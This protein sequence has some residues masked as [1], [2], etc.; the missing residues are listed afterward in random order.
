[1]RVLDQALNKAMGT[2]REGDFLVMAAIDKF[3]NPNDTHGHDTGDEVL[4]WWQPLWMTPVSGQRLTLMVARSLPW[5]PLI[6]VC[7]A[8]S[9]AKVAALGEA[10]I[11]EPKRSEDGT[12]RVSS[13]S[14][15]QKAQ[16][17]GH[18]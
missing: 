5:E 13:F 18:K 4:N 16:F 7:E 10:N 15:V 9:A 11:S 1:M 17:I 3:N 14:C 12:R 6:N 2:L 8:V